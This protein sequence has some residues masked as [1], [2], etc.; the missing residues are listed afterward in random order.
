MINWRVAISHKKCTILV[1]FSF[2]RRV[3]LVWGKWKTTFSFVLQWRWVHLWIFNINYN[4]MCFYLFCV[5]FFLQNHEHLSN[6]QT[7][8]TRCSHSEP[9]ASD[10]WSRSCSSSPPSP[11][12]PPRRPWSWHNLRSLN[13]MSSISLP[14]ADLSIFRVR[15]RR[16]PSERLRKSWREN[17]CSRR[18]NIDLIDRLLFWLLCRLVRGQF[19][20]CVKFLRFWGGDV[21]WSRLR[22]WIWTNFTAPCRSRFSIANRRIQQ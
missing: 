16:F 5:F 10:C 19:P 4:I 1:V 18:S 12:L 13:L 22:L 7:I 15:L 20:I 9:P 6:L 11:L 14:R 3:W 17:L 21:I 2:S 8:Q